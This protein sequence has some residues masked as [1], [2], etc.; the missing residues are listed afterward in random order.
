[1]TLTVSVRDASISPDGVY[2]YALFRRWDP[3][4]PNLTWI[5]LN[6]STADAN[7]DDPTVRKCIGFARRLGFGG[8][9]IVNLF[10]YRATDPSQLRGATDPIGPANRSALKV[11]AYGFC[12]V[13]WGATPTPPKPLEILRNRPLWCLG[14]TKDGSP[15]HPL[16]V[17][18]ETP[19][20]PWWV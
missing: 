13:G 8:I 19:L 16:Y 4:P 11:L 20:Q 9:T 18:Y 17:S 6:P 14:Q 5:L 10:A 7:T 3:S 1:M 12:V 2:R 15:R